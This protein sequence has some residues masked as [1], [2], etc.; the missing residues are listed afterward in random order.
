MKLI[1]A[2]LFACYVLNLNG[3]T[4][5]FVTPNS[6]HSAYDINQDSSLV[7]FDNSIQNGKLV[8]FLGGTNSSTDNYAALR[9][10]VVDLGYNF[11]NLS[12]PNTVPAATLSN[13]TDN[14]AFDHYR[15]E[16]CYGTPVSSAILVDTLNSIH[17]RVL[18]LLLYLDLNFPTHNWSTYLN[19]N[20]TINW[21]NIVIAGHSQGSGHAAYLAKSNSVERVLMF[22]GPNDY[23]DY[24]SSAGQWLNAQSVT[25]NYKYYTY[26]SLLDE[27]V[28][29]EKQ[30]ANI[31][32]LDVVGDSTHVDHITPPF[33]NS[34]HLYTTQP[35][36]F[37]ILNHSSPVKFSLKNYDVWTYMLT[38]N[39]TTGL[40]HNDSQTIHIYPNPTSDIL[41]LNHSGTLNSSRYSIYTIN[42]ELVKQGLLKTNE[43]PVNRLTPGTYFLSIDQTKHTKFIVR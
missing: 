21:I 3:Q 43:I 37:T 30:Y 38:S 10:K 9:N 25:P 4:T 5:F 40:H 34:N 28:D 13:S 19:S 1:L 2:L 23:S 20:T 14:L 8:L 11:I 31:I 26:L 29:Y 32:A 7:S 35:P 33:N 41:K 15:Q 36:G 16:I 24:F 42:G 12:Y 27:V 17:S 18:N 22:A 6:T 39:L